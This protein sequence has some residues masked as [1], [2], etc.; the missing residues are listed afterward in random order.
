MWIIKQQVTWLSYWLKGLALTFRIIS[1]IL[2]FSEQSK[3][4]WRLIFCWFSIVSIVT[5][6]ET[7]L[8]VSVCGTHCL[9]IDWVNTGRSDRG[10]CM[11]GCGGISRSIRE[12][13]DEYEEKNNAE[14]S[15]LLHEIFKAL[16]KRLMFV[17]LINPIYLSKTNCSSHEG[18]W[19]WEWGS[20][21]LA[22]H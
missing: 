16:T 13:S 8:T 10:G 22:L 20:S 18:C 2:G 17:C 6:R 5:I 15:K 4:P 12:P 19:M 11:K 14:L 7:T 9:R 3:T 1:E 21:L